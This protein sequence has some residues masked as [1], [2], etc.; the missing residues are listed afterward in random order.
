MKENKFIN[1]K[2]D[3]FK[4]DEMTF[5]GYGAY[6]G[7]IDSYGDII[8]KGAFNDALMEIAKTGNYPAM[9]S[10]HGIDSYTPVGIYTLIKEDEKGLYVEGKLADTQ[11]GRD[12]YALM[13]MTPRPA[14][15]GLS[16][17]FRVKEAEFP[18]NIKGCER[19]IKSVDL[20]EISIVTFP[21]NKKATITNVKSEI[22]VRE[23][24]M[25][26]KEAGYSAK[27]A[28]TIISIIKRKEKQE[29]EVE[30]TTITSDAPINDITDCTPDT[31]DTPDSPD[32]DD[33]PDTEDTNACGGPRKKKVVKSVE[34]SVL[35]DLRS[36][37]DYVKSRENP[38]SDEETD[39]LRAWLTE[40]KKED[41]LR[42]ILNAIK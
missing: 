34:D 4:A 10:Q 28:K 5:S 17:G 6:F 31:P 41:E 40:E 16:I 26:L 42:A 22:D 9:L 25:S 14:I 33:T 24:E 13:K 11:E 18:T 20:L 37:V 2:S 38:F 15:K 36:F 27:E 12:L 23:A 19:I 30:E 39:S 32:M 29:S 21:A 35:D 7:N 8:Q 3:D 1:I